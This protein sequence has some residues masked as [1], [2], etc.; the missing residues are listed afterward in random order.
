MMDS[1]SIDNILLAE[2]CY[3]NGT[4]FKGGMGFVV[5][6]FEVD[7]QG[8]SMQFSSS[9]FQCVVT[10]SSSDMVSLR[11]CFCWILFI[12]YSFLW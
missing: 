8:N 10:V 1:R 7:Q 2:M 9:A 5:L 11:E 12:F 4:S 3:Q 6:M